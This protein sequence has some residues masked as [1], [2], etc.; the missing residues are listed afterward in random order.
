ML[1]QKQVNFEHYLALFSALNKVFNED[2]NLFFARGTSH[3]WPRATAEELLQGFQNY[4]KDNSKQLLEKISKGELV[5][6]REY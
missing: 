3:Y 4:T 6:L 1:S 2:E 5:D